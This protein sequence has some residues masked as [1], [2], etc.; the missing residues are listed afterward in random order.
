[1]PSPASSFARALLLAALA[2]VA[3]AQGTLTARLEDYATAPL[4]GQLVGSTDNAIYAARINFLREEPGGNATR[5]FVNDLNGK[6]QILDRTTRQ[7]TTYLDFHRNV[8]ETTSA[9]GLFPAFTRANGYANGLVT[10]QFDPEYATPG[11][12]HRGK[13]YTVHLE[14]DTPDGDPR[15]LPVASSFPGYNNAAA[16]TPTPVLEAPGTDNSGTRHA[17]LIAWQDSDPADAVFQGTARELLRIEFNGRIHPLGDLAFN[18]RATSPANPDY[19]LLYVAVGDGGAGEQNNATLHP[20]PQRLDTVQGK[21]LRISPDDPDGP[22]PLTYGF[23]NDN[24][25]H[26]PAVT[27]LAGT[28]PEIWAWGFRNPHRLA[29]DPA[30]GALLV[31]DIGFRSWEEVNVVRRGANYGWGER[32]GTFALDLRTGAA[33]LPLPADD[34]RS[35]YTYP[36]L[37]YPHRPALGIG[38]AIA[39]GFVYR[40]TRLPELRGKYVFGDITTGRLYY[41]DLAEMLAAD[42]GNPATLAAFHPLEVLWDNPRDAAGPQRYD[43]LYEIVL[44]TYRARGGPRDTLPGSATVSDL[45]GGGR[46]DIRLAVDHAGELYV[47]SK[48]DG[49]IRALTGIAVPAAP[50]TFVSHPQA[51]TVAAGATVVLTAQAGGD[52][53]RYQWLRNG[54]PIAGAT[55]SILTVRNASP[56]VAGEYRVDAINLAGSTASAGARLTVDATEP[57]GRLRNLSIRSTAGTGDRTLI[58]GFALD[59]PPDATFTDPLLLRALGPTLADFGLNSFL[60]DPTLSLYRGPALL[61]TADNWWEPFENALD[62]FSLRFRTFPLRPGTRDAVLTGPT[63]GRGAYSVQVGSA[64][65]GQ[66][67]LALAEIY[68]VPGPLPAARQLVNLSARTHV[69]TGEQ[70]L[71][72]GFVLGGSTARTVLIRAAGPALGRFGVAGTL[73]DPRLTLYRDDAV[74]ATNDNWDSRPELVDLFDQVGAFEFV[75]RSRDAALLATLPPRAYTV[76]V[77]GLGTG[78]AATGVALVEI[79]VLP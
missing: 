67:G 41:A 52:V 4:S 53:V 57:A 59:G 10:F 35:G 60:P 66:T 24:P 26:G 62:G 18:P 28:R 38:D 12:P 71:I 21:I 34:A 20:T 47:L 16:Y 76:Q 70:V 13:F 9:N 43:R 73:P 54:A 19:R 25:F 49:M 46:A 68:D 27:V 50:P 22:G 29:F 15:R 42:D 64:V 44:D 40:G 33:H 14:L 58:V 37:Q 55:G 72:A 6:L 30:T 75:A 7:F 39:G 36:V 17:V 5:F 48:S 8:A 2:P 63:L 3:A 56:A 78:A 61:A 51:A 23:P 77:S 31:A 79:Y 32:E 45:T 74:I 1:M 69:G 11:S 65:A